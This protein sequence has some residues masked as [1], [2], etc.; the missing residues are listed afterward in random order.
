MQRDWSETNAAE[1]I[2]FLF[3]LTDGSEENPFNSKN[4][5][6]AMKDFNLAMKKVHESIKKIYENI[7]FNKINFG[8]IF[9]FL[10]K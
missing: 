2:K 1:E 8:E 7:E 4:K 5:L 9:S 6:L 3:C 10:E